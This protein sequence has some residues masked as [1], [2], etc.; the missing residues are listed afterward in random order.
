MIKAVWRRPLALLLLYYKDPK[1][2][3]LHP[4]NQ[5]HDSQ[6]S[7]R[8][9][10][11]LFLLGVLVHVFQLKHFLYGS[12]N[13]ISDKRTSYYNHAEEETEAQ[14]NV[15]DFVSLFQDHPRFGDNI[16]EK[17]QIIEPVPDS[18]LSDMQQKVCQNLIGSIISKLL[19][20]KFILQWLCKLSNCHKLCEQI[21]KI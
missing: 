18:I 1:Y 5:L 16:D 2:L 13:I 19:R 6:S 21:S 11:S 3:V 20:L 10:V 12:E 17:K 7:H 14:G 15:T 8:R 9:N 4:R